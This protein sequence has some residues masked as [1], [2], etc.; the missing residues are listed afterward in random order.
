MSPTRLLHF[1]KKEYPT[2]VDLAERWKKITAK[3]KSLGFT[4]IHK[5]GSVVKMLE[6]I[7]D[8]EVIVLTPEE[9]SDLTNGEVKVRG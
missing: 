3:A 9:L 2:S 7:T 8:G 5:K 6:A 4:T 1:S